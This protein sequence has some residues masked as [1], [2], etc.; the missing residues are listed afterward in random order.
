M[1][2]APQNSPKSSD[3]PDIDSQVVL[4][5]P[6]VDA[7]DQEKADYAFTRWRVQGDHYAGYAR[8]WT[9]V[10][11]FLVGKHW[12]TWK[13]DIRLY[14]PE[15]NVPKWRQQP[16]TNLVFGLPDSPSQAHQAATGL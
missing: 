1:A 3:N 5:A 12:L 9:R 2:E 13:K 14:V 6:G 8:Y 10:I 11:L 15:R 7:D 4:E 16:V